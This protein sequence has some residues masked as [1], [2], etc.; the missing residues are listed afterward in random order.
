M[1]RVETIHP[2]VV[3]VQVLEQGS[4]ASS[5]LQATRSASLLV[6]GTHHRGLLAGALLG[7]TGQDVLSQCRIPVC[8]VPRDASN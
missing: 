8:V 1:Q 4:P 7:S 5:L 3:T 2:G 6:I